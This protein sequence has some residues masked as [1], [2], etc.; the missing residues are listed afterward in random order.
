MRNICL[1]VWKK[2]ANVFSVAVIK[3]VFYLVMV[4]FGKELISGHKA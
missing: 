2:R 4:L 3:L 1:Y